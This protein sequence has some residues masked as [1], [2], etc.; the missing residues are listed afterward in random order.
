MP[1]SLREAAR[2]GDATAADLESGAA[3]AHLL[4]KLQTVSETV[5]SDSV[6]R[7]PADMAA[8]FKHLLV[9]LWIGI[10]DACRR[11]SSPVLAVRPSNTD[12]VFKWGMDCPDCIYT[13]SGLR[14]GDTYRLWGNRGSARYV[15]LQT[16][17]GMASTANVLLDE[18]ELESNGD[19]EMILSGDEQS[20]NWMKVADDATQL[21]VRHFF[22]DWDAEV[23]STLHI[24][25]LS[26]PPPLPPSAAVDPQTAM[27]RQLVA[28]GDFVEANLDFFLQFAR[29]EN[30]NM[31]NPPYDGTA[32]G[33]AAEN[34]P[35]MGSWE[36]AADEALVV[37][38]EPPR[39]LYWSYSLG[40][41]W[42]ETIDYGRHQSSLNGHQAVV[43]DDGLLR[44]VIAHEDPGF[45]NWLDTAG[46]SAGPVILR[47]VRTETAPVPTTRVVKFADV[48]A[49]LPAGTHRVTP[50]A[51]AA[52]MEKRRIAVSRRF[53]R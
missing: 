4:A 32:M 5:L 27:A 39:G 19:F 40:N 7:N 42:W 50:D 24:E 21:V 51:R 8:G 25:K 28:L 10:D 48:A 49:E 26:G 12:A 46:H 22:Y 34:R 20:G 18:I 15:G 53:A 9:L 16:M 31:F 23:A 38:V 11:D 44:V 17:A 47:C 13:G 3:W 45:A 14:G 29:P 35:V 41:P 37:E 36:L 43:D 6:P 1:S 2:A 33:A 52:T 30:P